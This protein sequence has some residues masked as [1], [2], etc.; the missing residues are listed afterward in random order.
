MK[1]TILSYTS[2]ETLTN[3]ETTKLERIADF[4]FIFSFHSGVNVVRDVWLLLFIPNEYI[5]IWMCSLALWTAHDSYIIFRFYLNISFQIFLDPDAQSFLSIHE[6]LHYTT[7]A[8]IYIYSYANQL[9]E[10]ERETH[11][12]NEQNND[13]R[14]CIFFIIQYTGWVAENRE[15]EREACVKSKWVP[16]FICS[17]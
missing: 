9:G 7:C 13:D 14:H 1:R 10:R 12:I 11:T 2:I 4:F 6:I 15:R 3:A 16:Y 5:G 17:T 8:Y